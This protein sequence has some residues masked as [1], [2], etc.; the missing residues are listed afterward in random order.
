MMIRIL[1]ASLFL[2]FSAGVASSAADQAP[3]D[4]AERVVEPATP[5]ESPASANASRKGGTLPIY[6]PPNPGAP[7]T[8]I[9]GTTRSRGDLPAVQVL[10]PDH[11]GLTTREQ[12]V[13]WFWLSAP[14]N[15]RIDVTVNAADAAKPQL[16]ATLAGPFA[17]G[18]HPVDLAKLGARL[19]EGRDYEWFVAVV[20]DPARRS[21]DVV[22]G[23]TIRRV[24]PR[25][26]VAEALSEAP[27]GEIAYAYARTGI[28]YDAIEEL[29]AAASRGDPGAIAARAAM[30][31][32]AGLELEP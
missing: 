25:G 16:E 21:G 17:A 20:P 28:W 4:E 26:E 8:R 18:F 5:S 24:S 7:K 30:A 31:R 6:V 19:E 29:S 22:A 12:P 15:E 32:E 10:A 1:A 2:V 14:T 9:A 11:T 27:G 3:A 13:L 23:G